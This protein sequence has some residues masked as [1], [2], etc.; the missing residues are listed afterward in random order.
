VATPILTQC[1]ADIMTRRG[2]KKMNR[3]EL[4]PLV[5]PL[6]VEEVYGGITRMT[7]ACIP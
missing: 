6:A 5:S 3:M 1:D 2:F 7:E 4:I